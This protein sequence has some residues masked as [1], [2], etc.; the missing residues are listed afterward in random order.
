LVLF[1][2]TFNGG[3]SAAGARQRTPLRI[4]HNNPMWFAM[5]MV[6]SVPAA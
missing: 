1:A 4:V 2:E 3:L 5:L 6:E